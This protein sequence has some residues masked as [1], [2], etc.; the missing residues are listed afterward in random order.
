M[1]QQI[2]SGRLPLPPLL[3]GG[4]VSREHSTDP[5]AR[6]RAGPMA[7]APAAMLMAPSPP[8]SPPQEGEAM[9]PSPPGT[10]RSQA[11]AALL[12]QSRVACQSRVARPLEGTASAQWWSSTGEEGQA[13]REALRHI[14]QTELDP[15]ASAENVPTSEGASKARSGSETAIS[16][17][18]APPARRSGGPA[19]GRTS[20]SIISRR[21]PPVTVLPPDGSPDVEE[22][23]PTPQRT[24]QAGWSRESPQWTRCNSMPAELTGQ[25][26]SGAPA[27]DS[28][29]LSP[30][31]VRPPALPSP[32][33]GHVLNSRRASNADHTAPFEQLTHPPERADP[34]LPDAE[35]AL[36]SAPTATPPSSRGLTPSSSSRR[37]GSL[38]A[39]DSELAAAPSEA[40]R[41]STAGPAAVPRQGTESPPPR[42]VQRLSNGTYGAGAPIAGSYR[43][44]RTPPLIGTPR[45][46]GS[47]PRTPE[48]AERL[49]AASASAAQLGLKA[50]QLG[51]K[52]GSALTRD[53]MGNDNVE[54]AVM[55]T[56]S[57]HDAGG[58]GE[59]RAARPGRRAF[60]SR[61]DIPTQKCA[62]A[63]SSWFA[64]ADSTEAT[65]G[66]AA[67]S[68]MA[69]RSSS[70]P[71]IRRD[72]ND[73][74]QQRRA[75][76]GDRG[77]ASGTEDGMH[78]EPASAP[79]HATPPATAPFRM[80]MRS[81][82]SRR[83]DDDTHADALSG[84]PAPR[85][86]S[87][88]CIS[89]RFFQ[90]KKKGKDDVSAAPNA[91]SSGGAKVGKSGLAA[92][93]K[94]QA[95]GRTVTNTIKV[96]QIFVPPPAPP[97][98]TMWATIKNEHLLVAT[99]WSADANYAKVQKG[100]SQL[101]E[102]QLVQIVFSTLMFQLGILSLLA[103]RFTDIETALTGP[104][105]FA[106][107]TLA[108]LAS[109]VFTLLCKGVFRWG[110]IRRRKARK[111]SR[112]HRLKQWARSAAKEKGGIR[113][114]V[115]K[116]WWHYRTS[117]LHRTP[118][119]ALPREVVV[120]RQNLSWLLNLAA[121]FAS[122]ALVL[123]FGL[124]IEDV[125]YHSVL[126]GWAV[127]LGETW[128]L[129]EPSVVFIM[130]ILPRLLDGAMT[131][132]SAAT[133]NEKAA[134]L[135]V[136]KAREQKSAGLVLGQLQPPVK[137]KDRSLLFRG[138]AA[139]ISAVLQPK[140]SNA[141]YAH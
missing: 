4:Q 40:S 128:L 99:F 47:R 12:A 96:K 88:S 90:K 82:V 57:L 130:I 2:S 101:R 39:R 76:A 27:I 60:S 66:A 91:A 53:E 119:Q 8:T 84:S 117:S 55:P 30:E 121:Y 107:G 70:T 58:L 108:A 63:P 123:A 92:L 116:E 69:M 19:A 113:V 77:C 98:P 28:S 56:A 24:R 37:L 139:R 102:T 104:M 3:K 9:A 100:E 68:P 132:A 133:K 112:L 23:S 115:M 79:D 97:P 109:A 136:K 18:S 50:C 14:V 73:V 78:P 86:P 94:L 120:V 6:A 81:R 138:A 93:A 35:H 125:K 17:A 20:K 135:G 10:P 134:K 95:A 45:S 21:P 32:R 5:L 54:R 61:L 114:A 127:S 75:S 83:E 89:G 46:T 126:G 105:M 67:T 13:G 42:W 140:K 52:A 51:L 38:A 122:L 103:W 16:L 1:R 118:K 74:P 25:P 87:A 7:T 72:G 64:P 129:V 22:M 33:P 65:D 59:V 131:P 111:A 49:A 85:R 36:E 44:C 43:T 31:P 80:A 26:P 34:P 106:A 141:K 137:S 110:N 71:A 124:N 15:S 48:D 29:E 62:M 11:Y 41:T